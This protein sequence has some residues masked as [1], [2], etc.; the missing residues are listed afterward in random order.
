MSD[1]QR[2]AAITALAHLLESWF[3]TRRSRP[4]AKRRKASDDTGSR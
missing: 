2:E 3:E 4:A 1:E